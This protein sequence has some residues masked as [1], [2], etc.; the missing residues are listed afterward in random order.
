MPAHPNRNKPLVIALWANA[1]LLAAIL[2]VLINRSNTPSLLPAAFA[3]QNQQPPIAGGAGLFVMP[4]Q[5]KSNVWGCYLLDVD[6]QTLCAYEYW[7]GDRLLRLAASRDIRY[8]R[9]LKRF[10]TESPTPN[11]V[12]AMI[13]REA[14]NLNNPAPA[15]ADH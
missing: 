2:L 10:N 15:A 12:K 6:N 14:A 3:Q 7:G 11:E 8:D 1:A 13:E 4:A 9:K 5:M